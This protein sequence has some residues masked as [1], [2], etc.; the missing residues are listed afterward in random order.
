MRE[1]RKAHEQTEEAA[2]RTKATEQ[3]QEQERK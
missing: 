1:D 3:K 2:E